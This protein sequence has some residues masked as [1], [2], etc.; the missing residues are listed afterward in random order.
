MSFCSTAFVGAERGGEVDQG[1]L[2]VEQV[3]D[4]L[5][6][7]RGP[8]LALQLVGLPVDAVQV[9]EVER[10]Y[11]LQDLEQEAGL[12]VGEE[13]TDALPFELA[14]DGVDPQADGDEVFR[15]DDHP[16]R[17]GGVATL[18]FLHHEDRDVDDHIGEPVV[19]L[20]PRFLF[21]VQGTTQQV[22]RDVQ[23]A[24]DS[25]QLFLRGADQVDPGARFELLQSLQTRFG[26]LENGKHDSPPST[27]DSH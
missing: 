8:K 4:R 6:P 2:E 26:G 22:E 15:V 1:L 10:G 11:L 9:P 18:V 16:Q 14:Q 3:V 21:L 19:K 20:Y 12:L 13:A 5:V 25:S 7:R 23:L 24:A 17:D 27:L